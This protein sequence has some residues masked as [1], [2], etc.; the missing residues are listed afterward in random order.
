MKKIKDLVVTINK[1]RKQYLNVGCIMQGD[2][3]EFILLNRTFN[4]AGIPNPDNR[5]NIIISMYEPKYK[6]DDNPF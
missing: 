3:N 5:D 1:E 6:D 2:D 4:P